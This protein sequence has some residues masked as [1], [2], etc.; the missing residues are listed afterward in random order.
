[1]P[2]LRT[3]RLNYKRGFSFN[4]PLAIK[5]INAPIPPYLEFN[6][7]SNG[8]MNGIF[9]YLGATKYN[10]SFINPHDR[11]EVTITTSA[12]IDATRNGTN[13]ADRLNAAS[14]DIW[15]SPA[16]G[17]IEHWVKVKFNNGKVSLNKANLQ[18]SY[19][20]TFN[21]NDTVILEGSNDDISWNVI[22][23]QKPVG[24]AS[25]WFSYD[26]PLTLFYEYIRVRLLVPNSWAKF[27]ELELYGRYQAN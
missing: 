27:G 19:A 12:N 23:S 4:N 7:Q 20:H 3:A 15:H 18:N 17:N 6:Y 10:A 13:I 2:I 8:D 9:Y 1:M 11:G 24:N 5:S 22:S 14:A 16:N 21:G 25:A 26:F